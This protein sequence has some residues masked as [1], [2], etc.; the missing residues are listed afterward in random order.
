M[1]GRTLKLT[2]GQVI[3]RYLINQYTIIDGE[4]HQLFARVLGIFGHGNV[5]CLSEALE[6]VQDHLPTWRGQN[7]QSM[8]SAAI[9][10]AYAKLR[11][12]I[13]LT[14]TSEGPY[15]TD[16]VTAAGAGSNDR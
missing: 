5:T 10:Y 12:Q 1:T 7:E 8:A 14:T 15:V 4:P 3:A 11:H 13:M 9:R 6:Q 16:I 2:V